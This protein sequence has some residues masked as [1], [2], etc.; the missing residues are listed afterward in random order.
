[1]NPLG[2]AGRGRGFTGGLS[3]PRPT[4][5]KIVF[6]ELDG[7]AFCSILSIYEKF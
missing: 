5:A 7:L 1:M 3:S 2:E 4:A 6:G